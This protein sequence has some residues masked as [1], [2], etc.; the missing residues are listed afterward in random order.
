MEMKL[1]PRM[2]AYLAIIDAMRADVANGADYVT[3]HPKTHDLLSPRTAEAVE[4]Q[5]H[6]VLDTLNKRLPKEVRR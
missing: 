5:I 4:R 2:I 3:H 6:K 1:T